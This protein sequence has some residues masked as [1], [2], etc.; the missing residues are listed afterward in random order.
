M[1]CRRIEVSNRGRDFTRKER[2]TRNWSS[3]TFQHI[4]IR[5][6]GHGARVARSHYAIDGAFLHRLGPELLTVYEQAS[7]AWHGLLGLKSEGA[8]GSPAGIHRRAASQ[9]L[10]PGSGKRLKPW[11]NASSNPC[12]SPQPSSNPF[13]SPPIPRESRRPVATCPQVI[14]ARAMTALKKLFGPKGRPQSEGQ[15]SALQLVHQPPRTSII[16]LPTSSGKSAL[17]FSVAAMTQQQTVIVVVP[18]AALVDDIIE[19]GQ[20]GGLHCEEWISEKSGH[21]LQQLI[22]VSADRAVQGEFLHYAKGLELEG[23]LAHVFFDEV[24]ASQEQMIEVMDR[25]QSDC[26]YCG[27]MQR[28]HARGRAHAYKDCRQAVESGCGIGAYEAW[29]EDIDLGEFQ[30]CWKCGLSQKICRRL[31]DDGWCEYPEVMLP[32]IFVLYQQQ[33]LQVIAE[34]AGFQGD[35]PQDIW[36]WLK[37]VGEGFGVEW[38]S[39]WMKTWRMVCQV[40]T[41]MREEDKK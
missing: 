9:Q 3:A 27:L 8:G 23:Q 29:R 14:Q 15:V 18:F 39:D 35:Y 17:F 40:Y 20:A 36:E 32:G 41:M 2:M 19:R 1:R 25:L 28:E 7:V 24:Q 33:H 37:E 10:M 34:A 22:V 13:S 6:S 26:I 5:Q 30:H 12:N 4:V 38:E 16:V 11:S 31:E 21:E